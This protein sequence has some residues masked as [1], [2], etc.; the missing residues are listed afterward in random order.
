MKATIILGLDPGTATTG[1]GVVAHDGV[2][3]H[4][5]TH[6]CITT[7]KTDL[8]ATRLHDIAKALRALIKKYQPDLVAV[9]ELFF[10]RNVTTAMN[11]SQA[12]GVLLQVAAE[13]HTQIR[14]YTPLQ[15][16]Q[17]I[18][19]YGRADKQQMQKMIKM[20]LGLKEIPKP[21][22]AADALA[23]AVTAAHASTL[24]RHLK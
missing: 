3:A 22:D 5:L 10:A 14:S 21:D 13:A 9:E 6:G 19:G 24:E 8:T 7:P 23:V 11:V 20:I 15:V 1:Y 18:T 4:Y 16:K 17:A 12:R 2:K